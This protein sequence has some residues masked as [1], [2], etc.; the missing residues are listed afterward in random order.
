MNARTSVIYHQVGVS[1]DYKWDSCMGKQK[2]V[3]VVVLVL[4]NSIKLSFEQNAI[5]Q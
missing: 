3:I 4:G 1:S 5:S 2:K